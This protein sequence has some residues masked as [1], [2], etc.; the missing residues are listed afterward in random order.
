LQKDLLKSSRLET[1]RLEQ[2]RKSNAASQLGADTL[3]LAVLSC[4]A[5]RQACSNASVIGDVILISNGCTDAFN[6]WSQPWRIIPTS[7]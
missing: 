3:I 6:A 4:N 5:G 2:R 7:D 1:R